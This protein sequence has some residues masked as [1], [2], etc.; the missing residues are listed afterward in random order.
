[1]K[2]S[3]TW[4]REW[5]NPPIGRD[6]LL[7]QLTMA[8][9]EVDGAAPVA[10]PVR[11]AVVGCIEAVAPHPSAPKLSVCTVSDGAAQHRVVCG[12]PNARPGLKSAYAR[13]GAV[14]PGDVELGEADLRGVRS[15]GMLCSAAELGMGAES[16]R[17]LELD[18]DCRVGADLVEALD[19]DD[20]SIELDLTPNRGDCLGLRGLA[21]EVGVLNDLPVRH[22]PAPPV[23]A[24]IDSAFPVTLEEGAGCPR[25]LGRMIENID[26]GA[27]TPFWVAERLRR[28][29]L[30]SIDP[31]VD[32][33]NYVMLELGQP[34]HAFDLDRLVGGIVVRRARD[35]DT[36]T[37]LDGREIAPDPDV[38]LITDENGPVAVAGVMGGERSGVD[39]DTVSVFLECAF[40]SPLVVAGA[41]RRLGL[42]TDASHRYERG[43][44]FELQAQAMERATGLLLDIVGGRAGPVLESV[45]REHLPTRP[46]VS[47]RQARLDELAGVAIASSEVDRALARLEFELVERKDTEAAGIVWTIAAPSHRFDIRIEAD[48]IEEVCRIHGYDRIPGRLPEGPLAPRRVALERSGEQRVKR[49]L[50]ACGFQEIITYSF[51]DPAAQDLLGAEGAALPLANPMSAE[52]SVMR[53]NLLPGLIDALKFNAKRQQSGVRLFELGLCFRPAAQCPDGGDGI[54]GTSAHAPDPGRVPALERRS[55]SAGGVAHEQVWMLGGLMWGERVPESWHEKP[56]GVDFFDLKGQVEQLLEWTGIADVSF[57]PCD[58]P[59]LHPGQRAAVR[60]AGKPAGRLGRLHPELEQR[61]DLQ[62]GVFVFE[63]LGDAVLSHPLRRFSGVSKMPS[64]RRDLALVVN[65]KVTANQVRATVEAALGGI[66]AEFRLFDVYR[67]KSIDSNEKSMAIGLTLQHPSATLA[68]KDISAYVAKAVAALRAEL[69]AR[70]R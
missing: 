9:L 2:F 33:T 45:D 58:D 53:A 61:L 66:L 21:R 17:I 68:E 59:V 20:V 11:G 49:L 57:E 35:G 44:D 70:L 48:L 69:N 36:I 3:E 10:G 27:A 26:I 19:L 38:L 47:L 62:A 55:G 40:F 43:V 29:G 50:A 16:D 51:V 8:G 65:E 4:L 56:A 13:V 1:M 42:H 25:Y 37:L 41:A 23:A 63:L 24:S 22:R 52:Q 64:V 7:E 12:A 28:S 67:G 31:V 54:A 14:L 15:A 18:A 5:V 6:A 60:A 34:M 46:M 39:G 32:V 30:R